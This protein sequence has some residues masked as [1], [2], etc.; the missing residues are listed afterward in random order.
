MQE[1]Q[2]K[3]AIMFADVAG[4]MR[5]Y[6]TLGDLLA[7]QKIAQCL[8][9]MSD[10]VARNNGS[11]IKTIG[12]ELMC[13]FPSADD[14]V[15]AACEIHESLQEGAG[16]QDPKLQVRIGLQYG[17]VIDKGKDLF[18]DT[19]N[20]AARMVSIAGAGQTI[21]TEQTVN[22]LSPAGNIMVRE[23]DR[24]LIKGKQNELVIYQILWEQDVGMLTTT[25]KTVALKERPLSL[26]INYHHLER[27]MAPNSP[28]VRL[29]RNKQCEIVVDSSTAS[30]L[31]ARFECRR[32]KIML[33]D[34]STN[35]TYVRMKEGKDVY[36]HREELLLSGE[37]MISLG[38][39]VSEENQHLI[40]FKCI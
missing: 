27:K 8:Q 25:F 39:P 23:F 5:L 24:T 20:V 26:Y 37:G 9:Q 40:Y 29:G 12:D 34:S 31:H 18:G 11:V 7:E 15:E 4:S 19:V 17:E 38:M 33:I 3:S 14:A 28:G 30:R 1:K 35:G 10:I 2:L 21:T 16:T 13:R 6:E 22:Q 32:G 36:I